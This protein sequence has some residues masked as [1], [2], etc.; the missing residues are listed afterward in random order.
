[1]TTL[2]SILDRANVTVP[3]E[4]IAD[5]DVPVL[6]GAQRQGDVG[7]WPMRDL[8]KVQLDTLTPVPSKGIAVVRGE[9]TGGNSH[10]LHA[11]GPVLW[12]PARG[13]DLLALG[14]LHVPDGS[15]AWLIHTDEHGANGIGPG[16]YRLTGK[17]E[18]A[19]EVRRVAD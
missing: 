10:I 17:R 18:Q 5:I 3:D 8:S 4:T 16:A 13:T 15:V 6:T 14:T 9:T 12:A 1:M 19:E 11:D 2:A 7:I